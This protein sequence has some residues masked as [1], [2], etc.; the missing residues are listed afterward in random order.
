MATISVIAKGNLG[1]SPK[2]GDIREGRLYT[3]EETDFAPELFEAPPGFDITPYLPQPAAAVAAA[4]T[5]PEAVSETVPLSESE[6][7]EVL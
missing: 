1:H 2:F 3:I 4:E 7:E 6:P 5:E